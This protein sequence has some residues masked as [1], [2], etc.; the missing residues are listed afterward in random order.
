MEVD[1]VSVKIGI[2]GFGRIGRAVFRSGFDNPEVEFVGVNDLVDPQT[3][4]YLL[5]YDSSQGTFEYD[6][7]YT[8]NSLIVDGKEVKIFSEKDPA[9]LPWEENDVEVVI[10]STGLF[11][12]GKDAKKHIEAGAK[13]VIISA[14]A[15]NEDL[16]LVMGVNDDKYD[17]KEHDIISN[18]SCTTNCLA[19]VAKVL[20]DKFGIE[21]GL[22][23]TVHSYTTSQ[24]I[25]D[26]PYKWKKITRGRAAAENI[27]PTTTG[28]AKAVTTVLPELEGKLDGMAMRVP[29]PTGSIVDLVVDLNEDVTKED[30]DNAMK[31]AAEGE[32]EGILGYSDEPKVSRDYIGD[33]RSSIYD[34][35]HTRLV[36]GNQV[37]ILSWYDNEWGYSSRLVDVALMLKEQG[38]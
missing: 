9:D 1:I 26:G 37:K 36:Q 14:P 33:P 7:D 13:K 4:A 31:E 10:E 34:S 23:T 29:T 25:L 18:A 21:K 8:D 3:L 28:A 27:V 30:I 22:M 5:K 19:P 32:L 11:R 16:T 35:N 6:V 38:L 15:D 2:N 20:N 12:D 24:N 17:P